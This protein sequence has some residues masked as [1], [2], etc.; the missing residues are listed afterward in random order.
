MPRNAGKSSG[1]ASVV[2][3]L[4]LLLTALVIAACSGARPEEDPAA[5]AVLVAQT[6]DAPGDAY[7]LREIASCLG[8]ARA[9]EASRV[10]AQAVR[11]AGR[12]ARPLDRAPDLQQI[13]AHYS[14]VGRKKD[15]LRLLSRAL[16]E[17]QR[18][19][20]WD[21]Q[22]AIL[23]RIAR[24]YSYAGEP[25]E[26]LRITREVVPDPSS[27]RDYKRWREAGCTA[28]IAL[29]VFRA[30]DKTKAIEILSQAHRIAEQ[31]ERAFWKA[32]S[33]DIVVLAFTECGELD[34]ALGIA[35]KMEEEDKTGHDGLKV[36]AEEGEVR[37]APVRFK[38][39]ALVRVA[40]KHADLGHQE[41]A[42]EALAQAHAAAAR[43][44][45]RYRYLKSQ[46]MKDVALAYA[47]AGEYDRDLMLPRDKCGAPPDLSKATEIA[48]AI[49][50]P[51]LRAIALDWIAEGC[52]KRGEREVCLRTLAEA[53]SVAKAIADDSRD[54]YVTELGFL[55][56]YKPEVLASLVKGYAEAGE[57]EQ[58]LQVANSITKHE[59]F[60][61]RRKDALV[62]IASAYVKQGQRAK[63]L[64]MLK[65]AADA[66]AAG[67][68]LPPLY[69]EAGEH[70]KALE[71]A[72]DDAEILE[73]LAA[74]CAKAGRFDHAVETAARIAEPY[75]QALALVH[76]GAELSAAQQVLS[77]QAKAI[78]AEIARK[79]KSKATVEP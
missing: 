13:A 62:H 52:R 60:G 31:T 53:V 12:G 69:E 73:G 36:L 64:A 11:V 28:C 39:I 76:I 37:L 1:P 46:L 56:R 68:K 19:D 35:L 23:R 32:E 8:S 70:E 34:R 14:V 9:E 43:V 27:R 78:L 38:V 79:A 66:G 74:R 21:Y 3:Y 48:R 24:M 59:R 16:A 67:S 77:K 75:H 61:D 18:I 71:A 10:L 55:E 20:G 65:Q 47:G 15:A 29:D 40:N 30:G 63:A 26:A 4:I 51:L 58:A 44:P 6:I 25:E 7:Q 2:R 42:R 49:E 45:G 72:R 22:V 33:L 17:A 5:C 57:F 50:H 54:A 41:K